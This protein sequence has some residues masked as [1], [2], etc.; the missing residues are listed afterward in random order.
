[1]SRPCSL[2]LRKRAVA[3]VRGGLSRRETAEDFGASACPRRFAGPGREE[4]TG[5]AAP[6]AMGGNRP[7]SLETE[8]AWILAGGGAGLDRAAFRRDAGPNAARPA[9]R[10]TAAR[11]RGERLR[12]VEHRCRPGLSFKKAC[13]PASSSGLMSHGGGHGGSVTSTGSMRNA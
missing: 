8:R 9:G 5:S 13:T 3:A 4:V 2:D 12:G 1:M 11:H 6:V 7:F 10:A